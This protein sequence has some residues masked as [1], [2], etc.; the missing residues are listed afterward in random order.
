MHHGKRTIQTLFLE[1]VCSAFLH[2]LVVAPPSRHHSSSRP[3][4]AASPE[5]V[6]DFPCSTGAAAVTST[7]TSTGARLLLLLV[8]IA[9]LPVAL[10]EHH[11]SFGRGPVLRQRDPLVVVV[12]VQWWINGSVVDDIHRRPGFGGWRALTLT[13]SH[14]HG[15]AAHSRRLSATLAFMGGPLTVGLVFVARPGTPERKS[16]RQQ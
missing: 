2:V 15:L 5:K 1:E 4:L 3:S 7:P 13:E 16:G 10:L 11:G 9:K 14:G 8:N 12:I 6:H